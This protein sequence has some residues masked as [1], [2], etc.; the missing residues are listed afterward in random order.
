MDSA[1]FVD[2]QKYYVGG[3]ETTPQNI[4]E[5]NVIRARCIASEMLGQYNFFLNE[6]IVR[7]LITFNLTVKFTT[8]QLSQYLVKPS[9]GV[10]YPPDTNY[11][12]DAFMRVMIPY[13][14]SHSALQKLVSSLVLANWS[15][16][17]SSSRPCYS[18]LAETLQT[19]M[20]Q[21]VYYDE[22]AVTCTRYILV[23]SFLAFP[24]VL[25]HFY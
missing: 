15:S 9:P 5:Q 17:D 23:H 19:A 8:G 12:L 4:R 11:P 2:L 6:N 20:N 16:R 13:L 22:I 1:S 7:F 21:T 10:E 3:R 25:T 18:A 14:Q 24:S